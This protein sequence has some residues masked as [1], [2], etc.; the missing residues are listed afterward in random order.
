M[1]QQMNKYYECFKGILKKVQDK[2]KKLHEKQ[3][4][5]NKREQTILTIKDNTTKICRKERSKKN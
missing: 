2:V 4:E 3:E 1:N 5:L